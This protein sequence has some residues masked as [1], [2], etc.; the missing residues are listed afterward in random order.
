M[1]KPRIFVSSTY[2]DLKHVR[3]DLDS[4]GRQMGFDVV[5]FER[6]GIAYD[7]TV[8]IEA[9]CLREIE[10]CD[11]VVSIIGGRGGSPSP[12]TPNIS[13]SRKEAEEALRLGRQM[14]FFV[15]RSVW[16]EYQTYLRTH[17]EDPETAK[18]IRWHWVDHPTV[19]EFITFVLT[20]RRN[21]ALFQ[22]DMP[23]D[24]TD[25]LRDQVA[26]LFQDLLQRSVS[27]QFDRHVGDLVDAIQAVDRVLNHLKEEGGAEQQAELTQIMK[28]HHPAYRRLQ[29]V[30]GLRAR[31]AFDNEQEL[32]SVLELAGYK[33]VPPRELLPERSEKYLFWYRPNVRG[34]RILVSRSLFDENGELNPVDPTD[35]SEDLIAPESDV[36]NT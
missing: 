5:L 18:K 4:F 2:F 34:P 9:S 22:F 8:D 19:F 12:S 11:I 6:G 28:L 30:L 35:W 24:I 32:E 15:D 17:A 13:F 3:A 14:W 7:G 26:G 1:A 33:P 10:K 27:S 20:L 36:E 31:I 29:Q 16:D 23:S 21:N 25:I